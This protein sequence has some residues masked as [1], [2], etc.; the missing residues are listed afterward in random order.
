MNAE[1]AGRSLENSAVSWMQAGACERSKQS[2][3]VVNLES[4][5][6]GWRTIIAGKKEMLEVTICNV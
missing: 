5:E 3:G 2:N 6:P 1:L 4:D